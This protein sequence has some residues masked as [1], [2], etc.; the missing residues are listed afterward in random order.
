MI[1]YLIWLLFMRKRL[2]FY[3]VELNGPEESD[4]RL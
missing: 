4:E 3:D 2:G 1:R